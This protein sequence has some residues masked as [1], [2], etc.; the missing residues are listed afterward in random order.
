MMHRRTNL[1]FQ[2]DERRL[3][4]S[5]VVA[6]PHPNDGA[7]GVLL[8]RLGEQ[9]QRD[10]LGYEITVIGHSMGAIIANEMVR[11]RP[12]LPWRNI[13]FMAGAASMREFSLG[14]LP[15][16][17]RAVAEGRPGRLYDLMLHP[18]ADLRGW[19][20]PE[21]LKP[22]SALLPYGSLLEYVDRYFVN[23]ETRRE[24]VVGKYRNFTELAYIIEAGPVRGR[25]HLKAFGY[26]SGKGCDVVQDLPFE[27]AH[28]Q[29]TRVPFWRP[30]DLA[31][32]GGEVRR[33]S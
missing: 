6:T 1:A 32:V 4:R 22:A 12:D 5:Q 33:G 25:I 24:Y 31:A 29:D 26:R 19:V 15:Y 11:Q 23:D 17:R 28:F 18:H 27:H 20:G 2:R 14:V 30:R 7:V 10:T 21:I 8:T 3:A 9:V 16:L 13:V